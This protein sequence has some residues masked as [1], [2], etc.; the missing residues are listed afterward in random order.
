MA[1]RGEP[2]HETIERGSLVVS[3]NGHFCGLAEPSG[4]MWVWEGERGLVCLAQLREDPEEA[5]RHVAAVAMMRG[6]A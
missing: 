1:T 5:V 2:L 4:R 3:S 6:L